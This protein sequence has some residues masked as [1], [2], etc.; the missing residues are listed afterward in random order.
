MCSA[1]N[2]SRCVYTHTRAHIHT[3]AMHILVFAIKYL[4]VWFQ[5]QSL[6]V[7]V[8]LLLTGS[9]SLDRFISHVLFFFY[10]KLTLKNE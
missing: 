3:A 2:C 8:D 7:N 10:H 4:Q 9:V 5:R 6:G 1:C